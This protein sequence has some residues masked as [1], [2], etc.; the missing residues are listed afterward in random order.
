MPIFAYCCPKCGEWFDY[1]HRDLDEPPPRC[2]KCGAQAKRKVGAPAIRFRG[3]G[4]YVTDSCKTGG[5]V[6]D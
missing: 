1:L 3:P 6:Q 5:G 2:K 4:F